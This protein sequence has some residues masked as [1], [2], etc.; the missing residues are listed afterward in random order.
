[1]THQVVTGGYGAYDGGNENLT[2]AT[3]CTT[4]WVIGSYALAY[5]PLVRSVERNLHSN[6]WVAI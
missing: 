3:Y 1:M 2:T 4:A 5:S 6:Q